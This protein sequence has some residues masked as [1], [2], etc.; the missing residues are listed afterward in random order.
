MID[1]GLKNRQG[2]PQVTGRVPVGVAMP[3]PVELTEGG[4][5][6]MESSGTQTGSHPAK[7]QPKTLRPLE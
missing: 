4:F 6:Y 1:Y 7:S 2:I 5:E 3:T